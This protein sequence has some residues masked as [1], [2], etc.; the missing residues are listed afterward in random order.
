MNQKVA[1]YEE[2]GVKEYWIIDLELERVMLY[3]M[4]EGEMPQIRGM[5]D[6]IYSTVLNGFSLNLQSIYESV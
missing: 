1:L 5:K 4:V 3:N 6:T 2:Y